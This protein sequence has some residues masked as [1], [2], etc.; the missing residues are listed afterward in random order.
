MQLLQ[1][2]VELL[3]YIFH[4]ISKEYKGI[5]NKVTSFEILLTSSLLKKSHLNFK[6]TKAN[7]KRDNLIFCL[8]TKILQFKLEGSLVNS[9][10]LVIML[11]NFLGHFQFSDFPVLKLKTSKILTL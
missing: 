10:T 1:T 3:W 11:N 7:K 9:T 8:A 2:F 5:G 6:E 4:F